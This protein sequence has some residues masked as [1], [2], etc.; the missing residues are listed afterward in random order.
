VIS[1]Q[2][3]FRAVTADP[4]YLANL[5]WGEPRAGH[6]EGTIRAHIADLERN[7]DALRHKLSDDEYWKLKI[8]IH[9]HDTF[10]AEARRGVAIADPRSHASLARAFIES[11]CTDKD[12]LAIAQHHD[13]PY[14]LYLQFRRKGVV[15]QRRFDALLAA[16]HGWDLFLAFCIIDG[17]AAGK[18][19]TSLLWLLTAIEGKVESRFGAAD[20]L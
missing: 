3:I 7:L 1:Y 6:P 10:K 5:D 19:R 2:D 15:D 16:I 9:T 12:L 18:D 17:C 8:L 13:V 11:Y 14:A 4:R 20:I